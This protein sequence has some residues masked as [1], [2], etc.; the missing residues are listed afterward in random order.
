MDS[1]ALI[2]RFFGL[3]AFVAL[4]ILTLITIFL[5]KEG[6]GIK[7]NGFFSQYKDSLNLYRQSG[8]EYADILQQQQDDLTA[9]NRFLT[10]IRGDQISMLK[11]EGKSQQEIVQAVEDYRNG[12][13]TA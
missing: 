4:F 10:S 6:I 5:F 7:G 8:L 2:K 1:D 12:R 3:N 11:A 9:L 13:L